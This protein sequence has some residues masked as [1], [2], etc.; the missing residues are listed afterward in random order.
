[1]NWLN[2]LDAK[3]RRG[4]LPRCLLFID[5]TREEVAGR[6]TA[7]AGL[8]DVSVSPED[9][10]MPLGLPVERADG[11]WDC[12]MTEEAKLGEAATLLLASDRTTLTNWWL[13]VPRNANTPNWDLASTC[14]IGGR[15]GL[16]L[17]EAKA[18]PVELHNAE[19]GKSA[20]AD[21]ANSRANHARIERA[22][23]EARAGLQQVTGTAWGISRDT[24]YQ[25]SNRFAFAWKLA[26]LGYP[27][28]LVYL[29]FLRAADMGD[30]STPFADAE[31][32]AK[33]VRNHSATICPSDV[34]DRPVI[35]NGQAIHAVIRSME[36]P[37]GSESTA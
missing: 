24:H 9:L 4:S 16:L 2:G 27:V 35:V 23:L 33:L 18:H 13:A 8:S 5:G 7:L 1:V 28:V 36:L 29:G 19:K 37:L 34:W 22:I 20:P 31:E 25:M 3:C 17:V 12:T 11:R 14:T 15:R 21:S 10:W 32:W 26:E 30:L 6:F